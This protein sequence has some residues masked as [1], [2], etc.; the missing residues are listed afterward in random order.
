MPAIQS[1]ITILEN[2]LA[3][4]LNITLWS[5]RRKM[6]PEDF[7]GAELP[8]EDLATLGSKRIAD[9][10]RT[11]IF[12]TIKARA[13]N[14]LDR[15]GVRFMSGW[16][17]PEAKAGVIIDEL[18][19]IRADFFAAKTAFLADYENS[20][21]AWIDRHQTWAAIIRNSVV[22]ADYVRARLAFRWQLYKVEPLAQHSNNNAVLEAGLAEE[23]TGLAGTLFN[24]VSRSADEMW[25]RVFAGKT[26]VTHKALSP[27][28]TL[29][30]KL[31]GLTFVEP[32]VAPVVEIIQGA[33]ER[34]PAR[35]NITGSDL[36]TLQGLMCL[37]RDSESLV[38]HS[39]KL[40]EGYSSAS[41]LDALLGDSNESNLPEIP[42]TIQVE[43][44]PILPELPPTQ[45]ILPS[46]GL[47]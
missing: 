45:P 1:D 46:M 43:D 34:M 11:R 3:L 39:Q 13:F 30:D 17:I 24:E 14:Y 7:G 26:E 32:H 38:F 4:N 6:T 16:A 31:T 21:N 47:W 9:P 41:V 20:L 40:I 28:R 25:K 33:I 2:L 23:V 10:E 12:N 36:V 35:G 18:M 27:L 44:A 15:H 5:A 19:K 22:S 42:E 29:R 37:L 8:P